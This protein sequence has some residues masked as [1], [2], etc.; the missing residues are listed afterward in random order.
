M[1]RVAALPLEAG[2]YKA[3]K[4]G[5]DLLVER[6]RACVLPEFI[7]SSS[8]F[9]GK[10]SL[11]NCNRGPGRLCRGEAISMQSGA[12]KRIAMLKT[13]RSTIQLLRS[14]VGQLDAVERSKEGLL[15][16][17]G[18]GKRCFACGIRAVDAFARF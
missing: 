5:P 10:P 7:P 6:G 8:F 4:I 1:T 9:W 18:F 12:K 11:L 13:L 3:P 15:G 14:L 17:G 16:E 2:G